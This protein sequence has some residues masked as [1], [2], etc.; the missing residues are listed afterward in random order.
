VQFHLH[1]TSGGFA[2]AGL[3]AGPPGPSSPPGSTQ[4][5]RVPFSSA[6]VPSWQPPNSISHE[7]S[8]S[9][10][11]ETP[12]GRGASVLLKLMRRIDKSADQR[13]PVLNSTCYT[14]RLARENMLIL[15]IRRLLAGSILVCEPHGT[16]IRHMWGYASWLQGLWL[17]TLLRDRDRGA[18]N[19]NRSKSGRSFWTTLR[20]NDG[21]SCTHPAV[22][23]LIIFLRPAKPQPPAMP[24]PSPLT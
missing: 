19:E 22:I 6:F 12:G 16:R 3:R 10:L 15:I 4:A 17:Y 11:L 7:R 13:N 20:H 14:Q 1:R 23:A 21:S 8:V 9:R 2:A 5:R 24:T 18:I